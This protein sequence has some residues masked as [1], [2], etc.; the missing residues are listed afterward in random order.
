MFLG[1]TGHLHPAG[2][3]SI[4]F[5]RSYL[6]AEFGNTLAKKTK[7]FEKKLFED[8]LL[9]DILII[10]RVQTIGFCVERAFK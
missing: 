7:K 2:L 10:N 4:L 6:S 5:P 1:C 3:K 9:E 8:V